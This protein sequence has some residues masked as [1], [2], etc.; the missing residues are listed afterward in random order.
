MLP[1][2]F[3]Y[4]CKKIPKPTAEL[5]QLGISLDDAIKSFYSNGSQSHGQDPTA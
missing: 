5:Q 1:Y 2:R 4:F 3:N